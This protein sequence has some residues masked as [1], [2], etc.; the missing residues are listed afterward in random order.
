MADN[1]NARRLFCTLEILKKY[2]DKDHRLSQQDIIRL[3]WELYEID[4]DR[5]TVKSN[6]M[7]LIDLGY[8]IN[9]SEKVRNEGTPKENIMWSD[10]Y[11]DNEFDDSEL[12][13][14]IDSVFYSP[15]IS[16]SQSRQLITKLQ[17]QSSEYFKSNTKHIAIMPSRKSDNKQL[18]HT[19]DVIDEAITNK[20]MIS[21]K[22]LY[23]DTDM[24]LHVNRGHN[25]F[26]GEEGSEITLRV[27]PYQIAMSEGKYYLIC[28]FVHDKIRHYRL[29][30]IKD[31]SI[32]E[33]KAKPFKSLK[34]SN[35]Q[36]LNLKEYI[37]EHIFMYSGSPVRARL[38]VW[39]PVFNMVVDTFGKDILIVSRE[40]N[41]ID[42]EVRAPQSAIF[43]FAK[44]YM[45]SVVIL[46]P[47][48][49][50]DNFR[51]M[52]AL[53]YKKYMGSSDS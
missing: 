9:Y 48:A 44:R 43:Q 32:L 34:D 20:K 45:E 46:E 22:S 7:S 30:R 26:T 14:L 15:N 17:N 6:I 50:A 2:S 1:N 8:E 12:R 52:L 47:S 41:Y 3:L 29:D 42:I 23:Y 39:K 24:E 40:K 38:R 19:I 53:V 10:Y 4:P 5:K 11:M 18:F 25:A 21:F 49:L 35:G 51:K 28:H 16:A 37:N 13:L 33:D 27:S 36:S 31:V